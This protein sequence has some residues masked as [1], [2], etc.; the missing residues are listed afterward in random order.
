MG[1]LT[2]FFVTHVRIITSGKSTGVSTPASIRP[3][4]LSYR[5]TKVRPA[6][7]VLHLLPIIF[8]AESLE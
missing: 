3:A 7:S 8:G 5:R 2:P 6:N 1:I 4:T